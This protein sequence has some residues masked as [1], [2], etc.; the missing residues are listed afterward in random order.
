MSSSLAWYHRNKASRRGAIK[1]KQLREIGSGVSVVWYLAQHQHQQG[2]CAICRQPERAMDALGK[3]VRRLAVD[4]DHKTGRPRALLCVSCNLL[5]G[6]D[7][8]VLAGAVRYLGQ[9]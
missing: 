3:G 5:A 8:A 1:A 2:R 7:P 9:A 4:H 6:R